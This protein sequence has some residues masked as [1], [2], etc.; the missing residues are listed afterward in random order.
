MRVVGNDHVVQ[1]QHR[2]LQLDRGARDRVPEKSTVVVRE[3]VNGTLRVM[4]VADDGRER[5]PRWA[6]AVP[7]V[8]RPASPGPAVA[9]PLPS[10]PREPRSSSLTPAHPWP[11]QQRR[12][13]DQALVYRARRETADAAV[14]P[15]RDAP[16]TRS[17]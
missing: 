11:Q 5:L 16:R 1:Y 8:A 3:L 10:R 6:P 12:R 7:R 9:A 13:V 4:H 17:P 14:L 15:A 2:A